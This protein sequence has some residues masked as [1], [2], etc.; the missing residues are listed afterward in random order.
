MTSKLT[1]NLGLRYDFY[2]SVTEVHNAASFFNPTLANPVTG[3]N[4]ALSYTGNGA[5]TC[6]CSTPVNN[7][8]QELGPRLGLAYQLDS[9]TVIRASLRR[10]VLA[11]RR[12]G[13][14]ATVASEP[15]ASRLRHPSRPPTIRPR[16]LVF[17]WRRLVF[18]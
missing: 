2:P 1:V 18:R 11:R 9:Q 7:Y 16:C 4:G 12:G 5:G 8:L 13:R 6:N 10:H 15:W 14:I 17:W 3:L